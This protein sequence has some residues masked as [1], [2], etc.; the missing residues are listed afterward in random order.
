MTKPT[1]RGQQ[2]E[3]RGPAPVDPFHVA[4]AMMTEAA[5]AMLAS[6]PDRVGKAKRALSALEAASRSRGVQAVVDER[7]D[8]GSGGR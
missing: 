8:A 6:D 3:R 7:D 4:K 2:G 5:L 1:Q